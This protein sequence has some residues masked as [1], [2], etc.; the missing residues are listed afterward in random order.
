MQ[1]WGR[2]IRALKPG[3]HVINPVSETVLEVN[4]QT[5]IIEYQQIGLT[6]DNVQFDLTVVIFYRVSDSYK[7]AYRLGAFDKEECIREISSG[8]LR[9]L[10][11]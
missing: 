7:V 4:Q 1:S 5:K 8:T 2:Y 9:T 11:G 3:L 6:K 10:L